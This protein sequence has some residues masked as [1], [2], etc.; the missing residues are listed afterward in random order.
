MCPQMELDGRVA[1]LDEHRIISVNFV[2]DRIFLPNIILS[3]S[4]KQII[5][6]DTTTG[7]VVR[8][9]IIL[10]LESLVIKIIR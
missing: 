9:G 7:V 2:L 1:N 10:R 5:L 6:S 4:F 8:V 3:F